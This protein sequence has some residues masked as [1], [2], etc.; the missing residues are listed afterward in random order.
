MAA[1]NYVL[2]GSVLTNAKVE[3]GL[4]FS[5]NTGSSYNIIRRNLLPFGLQQCFDTHW[6]DPRLNDANKKP[7]S[8]AEMVFLTVLF[9]KIHYV[10]KFVVA[11]YLAIDVIVRTAF[12][13]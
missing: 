4:H 11:G 1:T 7:L 13:N 3:E 2:S 10:A 6:K 12:L 5:L 8:I 9:G